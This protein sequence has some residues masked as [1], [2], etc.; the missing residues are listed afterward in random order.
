MRGSLQRLAMVVLLLLAVSM[1]TFAAMNVLGDPLF[2]ILGPIAGDT[3]NPESLAKIDAAKAQYYLDK[4]LPERYVR[5]LGDFITGDFGVR[6]GSDGQPP[7]SGLIKERLP[8]SL[9]LMGM[10]QV[11]A[12]AIAIPW[13]VFT[14]SRANKPSDKISTISSFFLVSMPNFALAVILYYV[15]ALKLG[16]FPLRYNAQDGFFTRMWQLVLP[17]MTLALPGAAVYQ[18]LLRTDLI[19]TL[20][21]DFI[22]MARAK[23]VSKR[24]VLFRHALRPSM[25][26]VITVF[27]I[28]AGALVGG[29]LV[30]ETFFGIPGIGTAVIEAILR[31]DFPVV[32]AIVMIVATGFVVLN[33][34]V[35]LLYTVLDPRVRS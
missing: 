22:L 32:L 25:F 11:M 33:F 10:A 18:R 28:N 13:G 27:G 16:W 15:F 20:Q 26:S 7:V 34:L 30:V 2:N 3:E 1:I 8:R 12:L 24:R 35:D 6:F 23:G 19:T 4:P 29:T 9:L 21:E 14:A 17:A 5:W 31:E